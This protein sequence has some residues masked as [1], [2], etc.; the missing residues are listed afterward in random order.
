MKFNQ[1]D[2]HGATSY[3]ADWTRH[4]LRETDSCWLMVRGMIEGRQAQPA[5]HSLFSLTLPPNDLQDAF[6]EFLST[7]QPEIVLDKVGPWGQRG[8]CSIPMFGDVKGFTDFLS[9]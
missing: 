5:Q 3:A 2:K 9:R 8:A 6:K 7:R 4:L 1:Q